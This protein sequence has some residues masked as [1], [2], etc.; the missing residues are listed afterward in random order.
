MDVVT[1]YNG[2]N[3]CTQCLEWN[4]ADDGEG[5]S[6]KY[7][8]ELPA[9]SAIAARMGMVKPLECSRCRGTGIEPIEETKSL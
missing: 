1:I 7:W 9:Q 3:P 2:E 8:E 6:W 5:V 4:R